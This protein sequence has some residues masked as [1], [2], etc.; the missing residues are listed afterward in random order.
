MLEAISGRDARD[1]T[2]AEVEVPKFSEGLTD[3]VNGLKIALPKELFGDEFDEEVKQSVLAAVDVLKAE[4]A[5]VEEVSMPSF[6]AGIATYYVV[7]PAEASANLARFDGVRYTTRN[8]DAKNLRDMYNDT[9]GEGFGPEVKRRIVLGTFV[10][11][12]GYYDAY[13][14]KAQKARTLIKQ[15]FDKIYE[16]F[17]VVITPTT[18]TPAF[19][20]GSKSEDPVAMYASDLATIPVNMAGL[21]GLSIP[22]GFSNGMPVGMQIIGKSF[23]EATILK[24]GHTYQQ[25]TD[26][27]MKQPGDLVMAY[28]VVIGI[29][30]HA[31]LKTNTKLFCGCSTK[32][33]DDPNAN[34]CPVCLGMPGALPVLNKK[35]V[36]MAIIAGLALNCT[37]KNR[38]V[39]SRKNYFYPDL[40]KG[41]QISQF[42]LPICEGGELE[43]VV[44][45]QPKKIGITRI[46]M[47]EDAGKLVHQG[48]ESI[49]GAT[50]SYVDLNRAC[51]PLIEIVSEPDIR[52]AEEARIYME[53]LKQIVQHMGICDGNLE[54]GSMR[55]D[56]NISL[57]PKGQKEFGT[58]AEIK[59]INSFRSVERAI[60]VEIKRQTEILESGGTVIQETR[61]YDDSSQTT[62]P[63]RGKADAHDYRYFPEPDLPPLDVSDE[64][65]QAVRN[66][67]PELP[68]HKVA[69]YQQ[70][71]GL[72]EH[73]CKV[74][75]GDATMDHYF[76]ACLD[77]DGKLPPKAICKWVVGDV[78]AFLKEKKETFENTKLKPNQLVQL[79]DLIEKGTISGKM[80]KDML[81]QV[82]D[83][84]KD[85][86]ALVKESGGGQISDSSELQSVVDAIL[87]Q[88]QDVVEKIK[89]GKTASANFL[90]GQVMKE[91]KGK[92][93]PDLVLKLI[94]DTVNNT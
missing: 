86:E 24:V 61:N 58:R 65:I 36:E 31:Q 83:T 81:A 6:E 33:G 29:E 2:S 19:K 67:L 76:Q 46:H 16:K 85:P 84:G 90:M 39:F 63:L 74:L 30:V 56:A 57:R 20:I 62:T 18:P 26:H 69:R 66:Q 32:F 94:L 78:N 64:W 15:D 49:A 70:E 23:D 27:H 72:T 12:S 5:T 71:F 37:V 17:D 38:S 45:G 8:K 42:D 43:V 92:A 10:L 34:V 28:E 51:T 55:A 59:N 89:G 75:M 7:A 35:A 53:T 13:Y 82:H 60:N 80:A 4:G 1:S 50:H 47:E 11:S 79:V 54:E 14:L 52:L 73:E 48:A 40:P 91:T 41:Y 68:R 25:K 3:G 88:N 44:D 77:S 87:S 93:K 9:R 22:C 21:P